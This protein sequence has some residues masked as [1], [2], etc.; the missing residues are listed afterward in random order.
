MWDSIAQ[1]KVWSGRL[2]NKR[3][4]ASF[5]RG[6]TISPIGTRRARSSL[7]GRQARRHPEV[8]L[9]AQVS[10]SE[11]EAIGQLSGG[12]AHGFNNISP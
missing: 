2:I 1:G 6:T 4:M 11:N 5:A 12:V 7:R 3:R 9:E 10:V 8:A